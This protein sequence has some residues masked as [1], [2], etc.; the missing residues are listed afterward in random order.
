MERPTTTFTTSKGN[1]AEIK[2]YLTQGERSQVQ[3]ILAGDSTISE[4][5]TPKTN[6]LLTAL[7]KALTLA[8]VSLND[9]TENITDRIINELPATEYDEISAEVLKLISVDLAKAK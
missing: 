3:R 5:P 6:D 7:E 4:N 1:K 2:T 9:S 8:V